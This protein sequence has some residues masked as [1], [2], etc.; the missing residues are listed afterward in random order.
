[1]QQ[2]KCDAKTKV[3]IVPRALTMHRGADNLP[4]ELFHQYMS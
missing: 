1:M 2:W 4:Q 3:M